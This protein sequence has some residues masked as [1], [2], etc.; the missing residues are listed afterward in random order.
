MNDEEI[1]QIVLH[2]GHDGGYL[3]KK[4]ANDETELLSM[5]ECNGVVKRTRT[6]V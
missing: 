5:L 1:T 3:S 2:H 4:V 6:L